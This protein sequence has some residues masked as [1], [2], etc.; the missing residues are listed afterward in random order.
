[1]ML[2]GPLFNV[3]TR[4]AGSNLTPQNPAMEIESRSLPLV[5]GMEMRRPVIAEIHSDDDAEKGR[6]LRHSDRLLLSRKAEQTK[7]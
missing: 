3:A 1:M 7:C 6:Y 5:F 2:E 4:R